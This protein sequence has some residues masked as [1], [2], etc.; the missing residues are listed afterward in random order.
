MGILARLG[1][2]TRLQHQAK[3]KEM[4]DQFNAHLER[5]VEIR[6]AAVDEVI[7]QLTNITVES[8][9]RDK[10]PV[11]VRMEFPRSFATI[12]AHGDPQIAGFAVDRIA[13]RVGRKMAD[14]VGIVEGGEFEGQYL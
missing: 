2:L 5:Q 3:V 13:R 1:L 8:I 6:S 11:V 7:G 9:G 14:A 12:L 10:E 4:V